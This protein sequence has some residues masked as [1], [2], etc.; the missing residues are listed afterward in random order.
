MSACM[1]AGDQV[2]VYIFA[3]RL[4]LRCQPLDCRRSF[5]PIYQS[6]WAN[7]AEG[8]R[9]PKRRKMGKSSSLKTAFKAPFIS[10]STDRTTNDE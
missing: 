9:K 1:H 3:L 2:F 8:K 7:W 6:Q 4:L 5:C 10:S